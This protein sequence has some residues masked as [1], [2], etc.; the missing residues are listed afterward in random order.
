MINDQP[1]FNPTFI[2]Q[3]ALFAHAP[4]AV[5]LEETVETDQDQLK[6]EPG[7]QALPSRHHAPA[8]VHRDHRGLVVLRRLLRILH[9]RNPRGRADHL[10]WHAED[11]TN[12]ATRRYPADCRHRPNRRAAPQG[13][14]AE[15]RALLDPRSIDA[16]V[17]RAGEATLQRA[18]A[19]RGEEDV[20]QVLWLQNETL[21]EHARQRQLPSRF[22]DA[23]LHAL[24]AA[25]VTNARP[26]ALLANTEDGLPTPTLPP[27][28]LRGSKT[29]TPTSE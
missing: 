11:H 28:H 24:L 29:F 13:H 27:L 26:A 8:P 6:T 18:L 1:P 16:R 15:E 19:E 17:R 25:P 20:L 5:F 9:L 4:E 7:D 14:R 2:T 23:A 21:P 22:D 10:R 3:G 12:R